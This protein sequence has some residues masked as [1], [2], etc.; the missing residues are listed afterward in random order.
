MV[1]AQLQPLAG[2]EVPP[3]T[4]KELCLAHEMYPLPF[5]EPRVSNRNPSRCS[6]SAL[7]AAL[8]RKGGFPIHFPSSTPSSVNT[9]S[10]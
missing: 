2:A 6:I 9:C 10:L 1:S 3:G 4:S 8:G 7:S 5:H